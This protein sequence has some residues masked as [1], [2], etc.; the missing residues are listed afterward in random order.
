MTDKTP[1]SQAWSRAKAIERLREHLLRLTD[2]EHSICQVASELGIFCR[3]F[4]RWDEEELR[5]RYQAALGRSSGLTRRQLEE[6][7][8]LWQLSQQILH[9]VR[10][11]C[12]AE[13]ALHGTCRGWDDFSNEDLA[14]FCSDLLGQHVVVL[15]APSGGRTFLT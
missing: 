4:R 8:N 10:L 3:G 7:A 14:R 5:R 15:G 12:D 1:A 2:E 11:A 6:L 13:T 9:R